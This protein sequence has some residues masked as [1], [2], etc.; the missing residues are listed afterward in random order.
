MG[1]ERE[2]GLGDNSEFNTGHTGSEISTEL[3]GT[4]LQPK[5]AMF[6]MG[7]KSL[8]LGASPALCCFSQWRPLVVGVRKGTT[9]CPRGAGGL[10]KPMGICLYWEEKGTRGVWGEEGDFNTTCQPPERCLLR[11][12]GTGASVF[13]L[14]KGTE[15]IGEH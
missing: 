14:W 4:A 13:S 12:G 8:A 15:K 1:P 5:S 10:G 3:A 7:A 11:G 2:S 9:G 6:V